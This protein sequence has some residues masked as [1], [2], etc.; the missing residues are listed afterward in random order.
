MP[1]VPL[2]S[3]L[4]TNFTCQQNTCISMLLKMKGPSRSPVGGNGGETTNISGWASVRTVLS[5]T[6]SSQVV[7]HELDV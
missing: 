6:S 4:I 3:C 2:N 1:A 7:E 5:A